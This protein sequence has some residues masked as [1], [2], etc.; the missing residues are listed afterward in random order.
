M[1]TRQV[2]FKDRVTFIVLFLLLAQLFIGTT[3]T[4]A[5]DGQDPD[6][7]EEDYDFSWL[8]PDKKI[9]VIQ[10]RKYLKGKHL[11]LMLGLGPNLSGPYSDGTAITGRAA[12][13]FNEKWGVSLLFAGQSNSVSDTLTELQSVSNSFPGIRDVTSFFGGS[14]IWVP[15]YGKL[16]LFN[17]IFYID[18]PLELGLASVWTEADLNTRVGSSANIISTTHTGFYWSTGFKFF[19]SRMFAI[20]MDAI[21]LYYSAPQIFDGTIQ[22]EN[23]TY[24]NYYL[25]FGLSIHL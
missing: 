3:I 1:S 16:N 15:F 18:W 13:Y 8:D 24:D 4:H 14:V 5:Q 17:K 12:Y 10:N 20:R 22:G 2:Y 25:T 6:E 7:Y 11:E 21:G 19:L 23:K 9:Y